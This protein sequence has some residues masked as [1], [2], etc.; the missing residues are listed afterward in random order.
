MD[1][2]GLI[3]QHLTT[4]SSFQMTIQ[5]LAYNQEAWTQIIFHLCFIVLTLQSSYLNQKLRPH[6]NLDTQHNIHR[7]TTAIL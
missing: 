3:F 5:V 6:S 7:L 2:P 1:Q 4:E